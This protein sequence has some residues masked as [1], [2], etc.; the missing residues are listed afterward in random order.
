VVSEGGIELGVIELL[1]GKAPKLNV[2]NETDA[3]KR[4][5]EKL[6]AIGGPKGIGLDMHLPPPS[7]KGR[8]PYGTVIVKYG[9]PL[10]RD[11][12][13]QKLE[14]QYRVREV[15]SLIDALPPPNVKT[16]QVARSGEKVG[17]VDFSKSPP[18]VTVHSDRADSDSLK[19]DMERIAERGTLKFRYH[20]PA[21]NGVDTLVTA[22][23]K[24]DDAHYAQTAI[25]YLMV[26]RYYRARYA[27]QLTFQD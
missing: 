6:A 18:K 10:Y 25:L 11:A 24:P 17:S 26:E 22:E 27:Y 12:L 3:S 2:E 16:L 5:R 19:G 15:L 23:A 21:A 14:P 7:G 4:L 1:A 20:R 9:D 8:G 13:Q